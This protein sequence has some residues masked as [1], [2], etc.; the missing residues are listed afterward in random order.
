MKLCG[1]SGCPA[2][3]DVEAKGLATYVN[4]IFGGYGGA[5]DVIEICLSRSGHHKHL[6][7]TSQNS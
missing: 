4:P 7:K 1:Y 3:S 6:R 5:R 2:D